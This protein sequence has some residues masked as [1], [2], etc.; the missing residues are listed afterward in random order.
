MPLR[1]A[2]RDRPGGRQCLRPYARPT[3]SPRNQERLGTSRG[4]LGVLLPWDLRR[5]RGPRMLISEVKRGGLGGGLG[6][7]LCSLS[8]GLS[9]GGFRRRRQPPP[10][11]ISRHGLPAGAPTPS[12]RVSNHATGISAGPNS[13]RP[14]T[15]PSPLAHT[16]P[17]PHLSPGHP[18]PVACRAEP[19]ASQA[20]P[21]AP[22]TRR[23]PGRLRGVNF[24][25]LRSSSCSL[26][27]RVPR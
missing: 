3:D 12:L 17:E 1:R 11:R 21:T 27:T 23:S 8:R 18:C 6:R 14:K 16:L 13:P 4:G 5:R 25:S 9:H 20:R 10:S 19:P 7:R 22:H 2:S 15:L 26:G 24:G